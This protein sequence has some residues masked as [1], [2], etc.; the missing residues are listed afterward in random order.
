[1]P[2]TSPHRRSSESPAA[3]SRLPA[4]QAVL[5]ALAG[6][7]GLF[8]AWM[9]ADALLLIFAG[10][11]FAALLDACTRGLSK[12][13]PLSHGWNLA[14]VSIAIAIVTAGL[15][16]WS[17]FSIAQQINAL[18]HTLG[19]QLK[20]LEHSI[21]ELGITPPSANGNAAASRLGTFLF[22]N[23]N[24][25][26]GE[27]QSAFTVAVGWI[28]DAVIILLIGLFVAIDP[29]AYRYGVVALLPSRHRQRT[30][31][32]LDDAAHCLRRWLIGQLAAMLLLGIMTWIMLV[33]TG[34]P[35]PL[36]LGIQA[37]MFN[38]IPYFGA[39]AGGAPILLMTLPLGTTTLLI[40]LGLFTAI[41]VVV[42][43]VVMPLI[44]KETVQLPPALTL[45]SLVLF[46]VL[47]GIVSVAVA[48]PLVA[49]IRNAIVRWH[50]QVHDFRED[51][52]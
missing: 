12:L 35:S 49:A 20:S 1:M 29:A 44:Q 19:Q 42:G 39:I 43:Y 8:L 9:A 37:G 40:T 52:P 22:P 25:L 51:S 28:G 5:V 36:L 21:A 27:A 11:L 38:F 30:A 15:L 6:G 34:V 4:V 17:G 48:T 7:A 45:A 23:P 13:L 14:I 46:G 33:A 18:L 2:T 50:D 26:F 31:A 47:F 10:L 16:A 24:Q 32:M 41:H 3:T